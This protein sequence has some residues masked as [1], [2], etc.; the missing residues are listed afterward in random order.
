MKFTL[1]I[2]FAFLTV[3][4][5]S[6]NK[7]TSRIQLKTSGVVS[8]ITKLDTANATK[9][10]IYL[11]GY[12]VN[13]SYDQARKLNGKRIKVTGKVTIVKGLDSPKKK[14]DKNGQEIIEQG[15]SGDAKHILSPKIKMVD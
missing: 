2:L 14:F 11:N 12:V 6:Q 15:R 10:G 3:N 9:D 13:I 5:F 1:T 4:C 8:F 7:D